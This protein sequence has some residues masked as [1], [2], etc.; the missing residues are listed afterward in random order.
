MRTTSPTASKE[1]LSP[2]GVPK[3]AELCQKWFAR[4]RFTLDRT[5]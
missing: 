3:A 2:E 1:A 5:L 4:Q